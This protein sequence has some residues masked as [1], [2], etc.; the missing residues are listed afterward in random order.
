MTNI[1]ILGTQYSIQFKTDREDR[2][3]KDCDGY[4]DKTTHKI[5][6]AKKPE[7]N[8]LGNYHIYMQKVLRHEIVHAFL[9]ESGLHENWTHPDGHDEAYVDWIAIQ[10][11]KLFKAFVMAKAISVEEGAIDAWNRR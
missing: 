8:E 1:D 7:D 3:L 9:F 4:T 11:P 2:F 5:V 10:F 6:I